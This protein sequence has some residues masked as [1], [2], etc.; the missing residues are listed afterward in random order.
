[1]PHFLVVKPESVAVLASP[2]KSKRQYGGDSKADSPF[3][4]STPIP[5]LFSQLKHW[6]S[7]QLLPTLWPTLLEG[8]NCQCCNPLPIS[9]FQIC[10]D[11]YSAYWAVWG[12]CHIQPSPLCSCYLQW[13]TRVDYQQPFVPVVWLAV[14]ETAC[15]MGP[16][17]LNACN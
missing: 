11:L 4:T 14:W 7:P 9:L 12:S 17:V 6:L 8:R 1:M 13:S 2:E 15:P 16:S 10:I 3:P 5:F